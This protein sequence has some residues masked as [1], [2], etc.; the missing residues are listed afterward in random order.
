VDPTVDLTEVEPGFH[1]K[2]WLR[3]FPGD[4]QRWI[5]GR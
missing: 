1:H 3:P 4:D 2:D 5:G